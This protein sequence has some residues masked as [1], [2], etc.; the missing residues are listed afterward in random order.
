MEP[1][2]LSKCARKDSITM[3]GLANAAM[4]RYHW[5]DESGISQGIDDSGA[6]CGGGGACEESSIGLGDGLS[7]PRRASASRWTAAALSLVRARVRSRGE[8]WPSRLAKE[9]CEKSTTAGAGLAASFERVKWV[10][11]GTA[12]GWESGVLEESEPSENM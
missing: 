7:R 5:L 9:A 2:E 11:R 3:D 1:Y 4:G 8:S 10:F 12:E 6:R